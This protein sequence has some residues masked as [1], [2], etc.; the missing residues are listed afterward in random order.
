MFS[1][2]TISGYQ[3]C[4]PSNLKCYDVIEKITKCS[5]NVVLKVKQHF[6][7]K[8]YAAKVIPTIILQREDSMQSV[9]NEVGILRSCR[10]ENIIKCFDSFE[11]KNNKN[12]NMKIIIFEYCSQ[13]NL[14][15]YINNQHFKNEKKKMMRSII[16]AIAYLHEKG[17]PHCNIKME[18]IWLDDNLNIKL[19]NFG[20]PKVSNKMKSSIYASPE[21]KR[22]ANVDFFKSDIWSVA[23]TLYAMETTKFPYKNKADAMANRLDITLE[24]EVLKG[25]IIRC[26]QRNPNDRPRANDLL[27]E[28]YFSSSKNAENGVA[29]QLNNVAENMTTNEV[30]K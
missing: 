3:I 9:D 29:Q 10:H 27:N 7:N 18:N 21:M 30:V 25:I 6:S 17:I 1:V 20:L 24:N 16:E 26:L 13:G 22:D 4:I 14:F 5:N 28:D 12:Q 15:D 23:I 11:M 2:E 8:I 19:C